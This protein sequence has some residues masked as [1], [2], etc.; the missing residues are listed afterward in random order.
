MHAPPF[1]ALSI[2]LCCQSRCCIC[3]VHRNVCALLTRSL[4]GP[5][6]T[7]DAGRRGISNLDFPSMPQPSLLS[8]ALAYVHFLKG[9]CPTAS[10]SSQ[11]ES[12]VAF[13]NRM[14]GFDIYLRLH[15][16]HFSGINEMKFPMLRAIFLNRRQGR[17]EDVLP[18]GHPP[19]RP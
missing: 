14:P 4:S 10:S 16:T 15:T 13:L 5:I 1:A 19:A 17:C 12:D 7:L 8:V 18:E 6:L 11:R 2:P 3:N 9:L